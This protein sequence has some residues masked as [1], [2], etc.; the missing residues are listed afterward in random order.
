MFK[1][2]RRRAKFNYEDNNLKKKKKELKENQEAPMGSLAWQ[3]ECW[4]KWQ[5][6]ERAQFEENGL[7][8]PIS[9]IL[10]WL[11][12]LP[13]RW[14]SRFQSDIS[15]P[16]LIFRREGLTP[17]TVLLTAKASFSATFHF[18]LWCN[19]PWQPFPPRDKYWEVGLS[20]PA[21]RC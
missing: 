6:V 4:F 13:P 14:W 15:L 18:S 17:A 20:C 12:S 8:M 5:I 9:S 21:D 1:K 19:L 16:L 10:C 7:T 3:S 2:G 11:V